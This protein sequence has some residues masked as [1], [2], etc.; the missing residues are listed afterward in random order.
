MI[1][2]MDKLCIVFSRAF[3]IIEE[4]QIG[5]SEHHSMRVASLCARMGRELG[6]DDDAVLA[7]ATCALF[8]DNALTEYRLSLQNNPD[9]ERN[10]VLHC[11]KGQQNV[12]WLPF[13]KNFDGYILY[14]H[15]RGTGEGPFRKREGEYPFEATLIAAVD[16]IDVEHRLQTIT[17]KTLPALRDEIAEYANEY[18]TKEAIEILLDVLDT[19]CLE[20]LLDD[21]ISAT[22]DKAL[23]AWYVDITDPSVM[24]AA[25][26]LAHVIDYKSEFTQKHTSQIANRAWVMAEHY[27]YDDTEKAALFLAAAL[28]DIGKIRTPIDILEKPGKLDDY[29]FSVIKEHVHHSRM[30][31]NHIPDFE[32]INNWA[33]DHHEKLTGRGYW[34]G[35]ASHE[36]DFNARLMACIDI[37]QAVSE[38]RPYHDARNHEQTMEI[39][40]DMA[41]SGA[42]DAKIVK[43]MDEVMKP[44]SMQDLSSPIP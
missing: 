1:I 23:P 38:P 5:A 9:R 22:I 3:D 35:K 41:A 28:H 21:N 8:H 34:L 7:L 24:R 31:L 39:L 44:Y 17:P 6:Y 42:I 40:Y 11:E 2:R 16:S 26:F 25:G 19:D 33:T 20:S 29:E 18:S 30:L 4:E 12:S 13:K 32:K 15:E 14:H 37:Y 36:L 43:D 27:G 10:I